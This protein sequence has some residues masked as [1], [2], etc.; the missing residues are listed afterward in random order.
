MDHDHY[1]P[2]RRRTYYTYIAHIL[3]YLHLKYF[4]TVAAIRPLHAVRGRSQM[5]WRQIWVT[6]Y[7]NKTKKTLR[8]DI[9][10]RL[11]FGSLVHLKYSVDSERI[12][13][14]LLLA[15]VPCIARSVGGAMGALEGG[16]ATGQ[17]PGRRPQPGVSATKNISSASRRSFLPSYSILLLL[18]APR[19]VCGAASTFF[20]YPFFYPFYPFFFFKFF[21]SFLILFL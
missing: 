19:A 18:Q 14:R 11:K 16:T 20:F 21:N 12:F 6:N 13:K 7:K 9:Y 5:C 8:V 10:K 3:K 4:S 17:R 2:P 1:L 15:Q